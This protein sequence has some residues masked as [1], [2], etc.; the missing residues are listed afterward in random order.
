MLDNI[1]VIGHVS[2][3]LDSV[4]GAIAYADFKNK[5]ENVNVYKPA[6]AGNA[7]IETRYLLDKI[8]L[9]SPEKIANAT[10]KK[11]ILVDHNEKTQA[12]EGI[13]NAEI[14]EVLD[15][16]KINFSFSL[17]ILFR[18]FPIGAVCTAIASEF[19]QRDM[20][21][22]P[23]IATLML[24]AIMVDTVITKSPT[25]TKKDI[26]IVEKLSKIAGIEDWKAF[27]LE[28]FK[29]RSNVIE[30]SM[31]EII[32]GDFKDF[33]TESGKVG[34]G[35]VETVDLT[36]FD[37][38]Q[39]DLLVELENIQ[40]NEMYHTVILFITDILKEGSLFLIATKELDKVKKSF[41]AE[42]VNNKEYIEGILSRKKQVAP[43][44][45]ENF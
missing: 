32:K 4:A 29:V 13:D 5:S 18:S 45:E 11:V 12:V 22:E 35:Q 14:L 36:E 20:E 33:N 6:I 7:N 43:K 2:P 16:H 28:L 9:A 39:D 15:H 30:L 1:Y 34:I 10:N 24:G 42:F 27:G 23:K 21:I 8:N 19:F 38:I 41:D 25:C 17:P 3:D 26:E 40:K 37:N 44:I 31:S